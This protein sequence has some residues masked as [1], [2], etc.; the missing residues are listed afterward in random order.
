M[1]HE[2][3]QIQLSAYE[4]LAAIAD[5]LV[6]YAGQTSA[7]NIT[8]RILDTIDLLGPNPYLGPLHPDP[9]LARLGYR[10][11]VVGRYVVIYR[12]DGERAT[13]LR[14]FS[15]SSDYLRRIEE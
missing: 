3:P 14:V 8:R 9:V 4:D 12:V 1:S 2:A 10:K 6:R 13:V 15:G 5:R 11:L 7:N